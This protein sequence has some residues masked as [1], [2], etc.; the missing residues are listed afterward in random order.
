MDNLNVLLIVIILIV[1]LTYALIAYVSKGP[2]GLSIFIIQFF[3][4]ITHNSKM[5]GLIAKRLFSKR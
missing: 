3:V 4:S 1:L 5:V 2:F